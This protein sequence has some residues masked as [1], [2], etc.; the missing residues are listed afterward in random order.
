LRWTDINF[1]TGVL[2][3]EH[4]LIRLPGEDFEL[5]K[6]KTNFS[7]RK[8]KLQENVV[9]MLL[10]HKA[11]QDGKKAALGTAWADNNAIFP[12]ENG[13]WAAAEY[14]NMR[15]KRIIKGPGFPPGLR[16]HDLRHACASLLINGG[17]NPEVVRQWLGHSATTTTLNIYSHAFES[18]IEMASDTIGKML[19]NEPPK[20][21]LHTGNNSEIVSEE[22]SET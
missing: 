17:Q 16:C 9:E 20:I 15:F 14:L 5:G 12:N 19:S 4:S 18:A 6:P 7:I 2:S 21:Y 8:L 1:Q 3:V 13:Q 11:E 22:R 10:R